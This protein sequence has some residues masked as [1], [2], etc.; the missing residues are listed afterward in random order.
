M[1]TMPPTP[2]LSTPMI[3]SASARHFSGRWWLR[4]SEPIAS[5][6]ADFLGTRATPSDGHQP[7]TTVH[8]FV[9]GLTR[10]VTSLPRVTTAI[11]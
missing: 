10:S 9:A 5:T 1:P 7:P 6:R 4:A 2:L 3:C 11:G 8:F